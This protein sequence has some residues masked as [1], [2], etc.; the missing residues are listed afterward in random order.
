MTKHYDRE[1]FRRWYHDRATR[2]NTH[3]EVRRKV[4]LAVATTEYFIRRQLR[5]V[6]D[7]GCGEGA[8]LGHLQAFRP[9]IHY[10]GIDSSEYAV[11]RYGAQRNIRLATFGDIP[12]MDL[13]KFDL[14][15]CSD[16]LHY[17]PDIEIRDGMA[18]IARVCE[19]IAF[20][21]VLTKED[22]V[23]GDLDAFIHRPAAWYR[24][25]FR[26][27]GFEQ[28]APYCWRAPALKDALAEMEAP[29]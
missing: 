17:V 11:S 4:A 6:L 5:T 29:R 21:E 13:D 12:S 2:V 23:I 9:R 16:V 3:A 26:K 19:G 20:M 8:W 1:Y 24:T 14:V 15:I 22:D 18:T 27:A 28:V 10:T 7:I 25:A